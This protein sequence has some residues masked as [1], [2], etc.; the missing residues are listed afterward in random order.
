MSVNIGWKKKDPT[1]L[2]YIH[3]NSGLHGILENEYRGFPIEL[4]K[5]DIAFLR[6]VAACEYSGANELIEAIMEHDEIIVE[7]EW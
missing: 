2:N 4:S 6:G 1:K 5:K 7:G 3:A